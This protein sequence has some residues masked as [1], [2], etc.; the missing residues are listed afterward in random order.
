MMMKTFLSL[1][2]STFLS[3]YFFFLKFHSKISS[4]SRSNLVALFENFEDRKIHVSGDFRRFKVQN[5]PAERTPGP[6]NLITFRNW[7]NNNSFASCNMLCRIF[8]CYTLR[9]SAQ[10]NF[11]ETLPRF[12]S[13]H[14]P[15]HF[16]KASYVPGLHRL[17]SVAKVGLLS[18]FLTATC[19][20]ELVTMEIEF[21][22]HWIEYILPF[23]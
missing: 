10:S 13:I 1:S 12:P 8:K 5:F 16:Y 15:P 17:S 11:P 23:N 7:R 21:I 6:P 4:K 14:V 22:D 19:L 20:C 2:L 18:L 9:L 3:I